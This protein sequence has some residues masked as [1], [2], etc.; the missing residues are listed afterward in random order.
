MAFAVA[1]LT[2]AT[3]AAQIADFQRHGLR[4]DLEQFPVL[5]PNLDPGLGIAGEWQGL[6]GDSAIRIQ[7]RFFP[8]AALPIA[9]PHLLAELAVIAAGSDWQVTAPIELI[10]GAYGHRAF[11]ARTTLRHG[12]QERLILCG[13]VHSYGYSV[14]VQCRPA[15]E[16]SG[17]DRVLGFLENGVAYVGPP[18]D[19]S[20]SDSDL[21][22]VWDRQ[23]PVAARGKLR[24]IVRGSHYLLLSDAAKLGTL[25]AR[26]EAQ[27]ETLVAALPHPQHRCQPRLPVLVLRHRRNFAELAVAAGGSGD[28]KV[29]ITGGT[30]A[31]YRGAG[32]AGCDLH[33]AAVQLLFHRF[34]LRHQ[35]DWFTHGLAGLASTNLA[36][37]RELARRESPRL[38]VED[39]SALW[40]HP[41]DGDASR[42]ETIR[43]RHHTAN[44]VEV[45]AQSPAEFRA[46]RW[47]L[48]KQSD[49]GDVPT[50]LREA[51]G[52]SVADL[53]GRY[54]RYWK[55]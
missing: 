22:R 37:R 55:P 9:E 47:L 49:S 46:F 45:L 10:D 44:L 12:S 5:A 11:A 38:V 8:A 30:Y 42:R 32:R 39:L 19:E 20:E 54:R 34:G 18:G 25:A 43:W 17:R 6:V 29:I 13:A 3:V 7:L 26:L 52:I 23:V 40:Q 2:T 4:L 16:G 41:I 15:L 31:S 1:W 53:V 27:F 33:A 14:E 50:A 21:A 28:E 48:A 35:P 36:T 24:S 51:Y